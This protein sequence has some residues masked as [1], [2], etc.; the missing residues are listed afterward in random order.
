MSSGVISSSRR[1]AWATTTAPL[2]TCGGQS[3]DPIRRYKYKGD[4][5]VRRRWIRTAGV[6]AV[7]L[8]VVVPAAGQNKAAAKKAA[9]APRTPDGK[10]D[11]SGV[12]D[13]PFVVD[14]SKDST[15]DRCGAAI[16]GCSQKGPG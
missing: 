9:P 10:P 13:H 16:R 1:K 11:L 12:W 15:S 8:L 6:F 7:L 4:R 14:M 3:P 2:L 5:S